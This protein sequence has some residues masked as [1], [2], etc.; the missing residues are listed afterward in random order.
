MALIIAG[1][2]LWCGAH[3]L[4]SLSPASKVRIQSRVG[5][6]GYRGLIALAIFSGVL[7]IIF[8]WRSS[9]PTFL[10]ALPP[11]TRHL[12]FLLVLIGFV[13][14]GAANYPSRIRQVIRH[15]QLTG[16][17]VW[18]VAHLLVNGDSRSVLL[19]GTLGIWCL[20]EIWLINRRDKV[21]NKPAIPSWGKELKGLVFSLVF[22]LVLIALHRFYTGMPL[23]NLGF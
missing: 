10:Y 9:T 6:K 20:L 7:L 14:T 22:Y 16:V 11:E 8:G 2:V 4:P 19:F 18:A 23:V 1:L 21:W 17:A 13:L 15:P 3:L 12:T 5:E